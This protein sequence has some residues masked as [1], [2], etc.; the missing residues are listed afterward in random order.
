MADNLGRDAQQTE[1]VCHGDTASWEC[2]ATEMETPAEVLDRTRRRPGEWP[3]SWL[4][5]TNRWRWPSRR[6][7]VGTASDGR[8]PYGFHATPPTKTR[9]TAERRECKTTRARSKG[10]FISQSPAAVARIAR[11]T[12]GEAG[13]P[14]GL[15][16]GGIQVLLS[17]GTQATTECPAMRHRGGSSYG[18]GGVRD[19]GVSLSMGGGSAEN[20]VACQLATRR[21]ADA[22]GLDGSN[23][24]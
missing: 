2:D 16:D 11:A 5:A 17:L 12:T 6:L 14:G 18:V 9:E 7:L 22:G 13:A 15:G 19:E 8:F 21:G 1:V 20:H 3:I 4:S 23:Q 10:A 24:G